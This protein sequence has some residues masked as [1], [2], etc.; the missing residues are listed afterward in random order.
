MHDMKWDKQKHHTNTK[1]IY[2]VECIC[3]WNWIG[4]NWIELIWCQYHICFVRW[5]AIWCAISIEQKIQQKAVHFM[6]Q[7]NM[8]RLLY[9]K[10]HFSSL[11]WMDGHKFNIHIAHTLV[12]HTFSHSVDKKK[13]LNTIKTHH[14]FIFILTVRL[15]HKFS[16]E[17]N[18]NCSPVTTSFKTHTHTHILLFVQKAFKLANSIKCEVHSSHRSSQ[19]RI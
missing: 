3:F 18:L 10:R 6:Q 16:V 19:F 13:S 12:N 4:L 17:V 9:C 2:G 1:Y 11:R 7:M 15:S 5:M 14:I 8:P